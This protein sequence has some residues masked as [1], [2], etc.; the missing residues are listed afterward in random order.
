MRAAFMEALFQDERPE[1]RDRA[2]MAGMFSLLDVMLQDRIGKIVAPL[3]LMD[4]VTQ[5][6]LERAGPFG[7]ALRA[8]EAA[9]KADGQ[10]LATAVAEA[11]IDHGTW[12]AALIKACSWAAPVSREA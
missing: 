12:V 11:G 10:A 7:P 6:L 4:D 2:F 8:V 3:H 5:A 9:E 1:K